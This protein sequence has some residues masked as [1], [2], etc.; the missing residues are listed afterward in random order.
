M[1]PPPEVGSESEQEE[2]DEEEDGM[3]E[4]NE[5]AEKPTAAEDVEDEDVQKVELRF[6][7]STEQRQELLL[8]R[9][10]ELLRRARRY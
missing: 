8:K 9:K 4:E 2:D 7:T 10:A 5:A 3:E 1:T 6:S